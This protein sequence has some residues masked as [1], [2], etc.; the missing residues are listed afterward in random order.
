[1]SCPRCGRATA[2]S[3]AFCPGCGA[4]L[5]LRDE[6]APRALDASLALDRRTPGRTPPPLPGATA[7]PAAPAPPAPR[8][9]GAR[10]PAEAAPEGPGPTG[11]WAAPLP[12]PPAGRS[13]WDL[14][15]TLAAAS[16]VGPGDLP[17]LDDAPDEPELDPVP[18][19]DLAAEPDLPEP[20]VE[21][22]EVHLRRAEPGRRALAWAVDGAPFV[23]AGVLAARALLAEAAA[24]LA[25]RAVGPDGLLDL[26]AREAGLLGPL[27]AALVVAHFVYATLAHALAGGTLGKWIARIRVVGPDG[28][29]PSLG[30]SAARS[31]LA[32]VSAALLGLGLLAAL[33]TR[34]GR[35]LHDLGAST[36][37]VEA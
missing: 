12:P 13:H 1:V 19:P 15:A 28:R 21:A 23:V 9:A 11:A 6:P 8:T 22:V 2:P 26:L 4:P 5:S 7:R 24:P 36:W 25:A 17:T 30:R 34:S 35:A 31:G 18:P 20:E 3:I 10:A 29:R 16:A 14:G 27:A 32:T 37:V 33:F